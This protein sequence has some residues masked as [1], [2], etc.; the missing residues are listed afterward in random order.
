MNYDKYCTEI[1]IWNSI[2]NAFGRNGNYNESKKYFDEMKS[3]KN[4]LIPNRN[5]Y[6]AMLIACN[7]SG[8]I[9]EAYIIWKNEICN[10]EHLKNDCFI[11][12][13]LI[14]CFARKGDLNTAK[15]LL[16][17]YEDNNE[18]HGSM[19]LS[20]L[21]GYKTFINN[22]V[23][24]KAMMEDIYSKFKNIFGENKELMSTASTLIISVY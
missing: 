23:N 13:T 11:I 20:V 21:S 7:H 6:I 22:D 3:F 19:W 24:N 1:E 14:D 4:D 10:D 17:E 9:D 5:I 12:T 15:E 16:F 2:I 18:S 8:N